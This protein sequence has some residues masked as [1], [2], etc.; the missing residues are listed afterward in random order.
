MPFSSL[1]Y[2]LIDASLHRY[3]VDT[4]SY[5]HKEIDTYMHEKHIYIHRGTCMPTLFIHTKK[6][7]TTHIYTHMYIHCLVLRETSM[8]TL[9]SLLDPSLH[10]TI[11]D[12]KI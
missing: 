8:K 4:N 10:V 1:G 3:T 6:Y 5:S 11:R 9:A 7:I 12:I 2:W